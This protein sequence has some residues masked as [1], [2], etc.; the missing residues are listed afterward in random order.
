M[1]RTAAANTELFDTGSYSTVSRSQ[2]YFKRPP[3]PKDQQTTFWTRN[4]LLTAH[5]N[6]GWGHTQT[7][8]HR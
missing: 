2:H 8:K 5:D 4:C 7:N 1:K 3:P 6:K